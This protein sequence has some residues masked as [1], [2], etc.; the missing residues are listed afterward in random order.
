[1]QVCDVY[2]ALVSRRPYR[3]AYSLDSALGILEEDTGSMFD[4][5]LVLAFT[6]MLHH[7]RSKWVSIAEPTVEVT[8]MLVPK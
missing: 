6:T 2:D 4:P 3:E 5:E 1:V 7:A 8:G